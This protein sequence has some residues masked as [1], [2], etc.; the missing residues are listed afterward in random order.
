MRGKIEEGIKGGGE[1]A[2]LI[3]II[4]MKTITYTWNIRGLRRVEKRRGIR[5]M[6]KRYKV[7]LFTIQET[8]TN[9]LERRWNVD[10]WGRRPFHFIHKPSVGAVGG[11]LVAW[12]SAVVEVIDQ[13]IG[14]FFSPFSTGTRMTILVGLSQGVWVCQ[15]Q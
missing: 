9:S 3:L 1:E 10:V 5:D 8:K 12:N 15:S 14:D 6:I 4:M 13:K 2:L 7:D 11:I